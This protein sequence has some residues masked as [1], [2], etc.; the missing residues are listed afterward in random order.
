MAYTTF[1]ATSFVKF[2]EILTGLPRGID[3][4]YRGQADVKWKLAPSLARAPDATAQER[5]LMKRFQQTTR[6]L[7]STVPS[8]DDIWEWLFLMQHHNVHTRLLDWTESPLVALY[9]AVNDPNPKNN[10]KDGAVWILDPHALN[11]HA[12]H[13]FED[14]SELPAFGVDK[15]LD[16]YRPDRIAPEAPMKPVAAI[17]PRTSSRMAAQL[18]TFTITHYEHTPIEKVGDGSHLTKIIIKAEHKNKIKETLDVLQYNN[19]RLFPDLDRAALI[20]MKVRPK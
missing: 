11:Q 2:I 4:W 13:I 16:N 10:K 7:L 8:G 14:T 15:S 20:A 18:G 1:E 17:G 19:L 3:T 12:R 6:P 5:N 9:F